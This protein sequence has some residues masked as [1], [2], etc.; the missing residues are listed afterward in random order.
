AGLGNTALMLG[1]GEQAV[2]SYEQAIARF[3]RSG[4]RRNEAINMGNL[5]SAHDLQGDTDRAIPCLEQALRIHR[6]VGNRR[7][8]AIALGNLVD[9]LVHVSRFDEAAPHIR[10]A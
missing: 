3:Q 2:S 4:D 5:G 1:D 6:E 10:R 7:S 9:C 8:E